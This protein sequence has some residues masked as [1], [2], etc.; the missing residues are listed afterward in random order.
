M[1]KTIGIIGGMGPAATVDLMEKIIPALGVE[2]TM[3]KLVGVE[4]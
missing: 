3:V 4:E 1:R 2:P